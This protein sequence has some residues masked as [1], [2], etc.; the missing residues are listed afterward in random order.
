MAF[1]VDEQRHIFADDRAELAC[2]LSYVRHGAALF[3]QP[4]VMTASPSDR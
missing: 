4:V 2:L 3:G 1:H